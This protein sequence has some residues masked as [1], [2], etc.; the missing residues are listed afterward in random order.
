MKAQYKQKHDKLK[1]K[2]KN[3]E[4]ITEE[5]EEWMDGEGNLVDGELLI[6]KIS[7][8]PTSLSDSTALEST[9][10]KTLVRILD[11][12]CKNLAVMEE[13]KDAKKNNMKNSKE[14]QPEKNNKKIETKSLA[15]KTTN[16]SLSSQSKEVANSSKKRKKNSESTSSSKISNASYSQK[17]E[18]LSK[19]LSYLD[20][21]DNPEANELSNLLEKYHQKMLDEIHFNGVQTSITQYFNPMN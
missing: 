16:N 8:L 9:E 13:K 11:F 5:E 2:L 3:G 14:K 4:S 17:V 20:G 7:S 6:S 18:V 15:N 21:E 1:S 12:C 19:T 10:V